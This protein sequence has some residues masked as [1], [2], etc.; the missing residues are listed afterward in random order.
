MAWYHDVLS[1]LRSLTR[2]SAEERELAEELQFHLDMEAKYKSREGLSM[3]E[4]RRQA[5]RDFGGVERYK[6]EVRDARGTRWL[7]D[8][9][10]LDALDRIVELG[11]CLCQ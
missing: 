4:A 8:V 2:R 6:E 9:V 1:R 10:Q 5:A 3:D 11:G 7:E